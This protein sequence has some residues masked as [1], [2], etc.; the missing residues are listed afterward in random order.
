[1]CLPHLFPELALVTPNDLESEKWNWDRDTKVIAH[2]LHA[3][4]RRPEFIMAFLEV[5]NCLHHLNGMTVK[6][7]KRDIDI[8]AAYK[9][10]EDTRKKIES[11][12]ANIEEHKEWFEEMGK[13]SEML[14]SE[15][16]VLTIAGKQRHRAN[17]EAT[18]LMLLTI[19][20]VIIVSNL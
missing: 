20:G 19:T 14:E 11:L 2:C 16:S 15:M 13:K 12:R 18:K 3:M 1:M 8:L 10:I 9:L 5:K 6:L 17:N 4:I 7:Q